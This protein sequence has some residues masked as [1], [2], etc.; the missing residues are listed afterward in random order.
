MLPMS[1]HRGRA[2]VIGGTVPTLLIHAEW[3][4]DE[5]SIR[6]SDGGIAAA[7]R[8]RPRRCRVGSDAEAILVTVHGQEPN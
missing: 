7:D 2:E 1:V 5:P 4:A 3:D 6:C 8:Y